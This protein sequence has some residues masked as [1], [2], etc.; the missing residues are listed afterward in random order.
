MAGSDAGLGGVYN[1]V[2]LNLYHYGGNNPIRYTDPTGLYDEENGYSEQE[3]NYFK[4]M[5][6][7]DQLEFLKSEVDSVE[8][9]SKSAGI[10]AG[11]MREQ[12]KDS[13]NLKGLFYGIDGDEKFMNED[14]RNF[15]N[16]KEDG[17]DYAIEDMKFF[18]DKNLNFV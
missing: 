7:E 6:V 13:M 15:L 1:S 5:N 12:L 11:F 8:E 17:S 14:L 3:I 9:G 4:N 2:N 10:K 16:T 18:D